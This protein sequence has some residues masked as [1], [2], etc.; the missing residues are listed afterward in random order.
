MKPWSQR[1]FPVSGRRR[2]P[3]PADLATVL[4]LLA[5]TVVLG[6]HPPRGGVATLAVIESDAGTQRVRLDVDQEVPCTGPLG[7]SHVQVHD[8]RIAIVSS[9]CRR[10]LCRRM[11][12][13]NDPARSLVCIPNRIRV[14][15]LPAPGSGEDL[16]ALAR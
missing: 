12:A 2:A 16:D 1:T 4:I 11:G 9:P 7:T 6:F 14:R 5:G 8:G 10:Q 13:T 3:T 15:I